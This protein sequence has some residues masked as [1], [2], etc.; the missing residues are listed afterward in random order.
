MSTSKLIL[1]ALILLTLCALCFAQSAATGDL[2]VIVKD[3]KGN[4]YQCN[5]D[6]AR[7]SQG[8]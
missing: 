6:C 3:V 4:D 2:H 5:C 1:L 7:Y 8:L